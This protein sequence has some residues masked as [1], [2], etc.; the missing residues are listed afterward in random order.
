MSLHGELAILNVNVI[1]N[2]DIT[3][4]NQA[5]IIFLGIKLVVYLCIT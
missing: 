3:V 1:C 4:Q 2:I 5:T